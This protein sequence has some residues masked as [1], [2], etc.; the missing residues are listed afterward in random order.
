MIDFD[1]LKKGPSA[2]ISHILGTVLLC[3][4]FVAGTF[5]GILCAYTFFTNHARGLSLG[6]VGVLIVAANATYAVGKAF[7]EKYYGVGKNNYVIADVLI[8]ASAANWLT[9]E[10]IR[11]TMRKNKFAG[12]SPIGFPISWFYPSLK[13]VVETLGEL[14]EN[15]MV[16]ER[17]VVLGH[18]K[19]GKEYCLTVKGM[20]SRDQALELRP[21]L[22]ST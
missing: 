21:Q 9:P 19:T 5:G 12:P 14:V 1:P 11:K 16:S 2:R 8:A 13:Y 17:S 18:T 10:E 3:L 7:I 15:D 20:E 4:A 6:T 22:S